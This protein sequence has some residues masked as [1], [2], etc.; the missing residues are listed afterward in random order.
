[1]AK[2]YTFKRNSSIGWWTWNYKLGNYLD[3]RLMVLIF[4][5]ILSFHSNSVVGQNHPSGT[6]KYGKVNLLMDKNFISNK[7]WSEYIHYQK[8]KFNTDTDHYAASLPDTNIWKKEYVNGKMPSIPGVDIKY[9]VAP[10][11]GLSLQQIKDYCEWREN[12]LIEKYKKNYACRLPNL[13]EFQ[14]FIKRQKETHSYNALVLIENG[15]KIVHYNSSTKSMDIIDY[16]D[17]MKFFFFCV[18]EIRK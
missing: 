11:I 8:S 10:I 7:D 1:M 13:D 17:N 14:L 2:P 5:T 9:E 15:P 16:R 6:F 12:R 4:I 18:M 3:M